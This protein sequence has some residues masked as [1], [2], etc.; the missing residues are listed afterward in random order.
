[1][2]RKLTNLLKSLVFLGSSYVCSELAAECVTE[3]P[4]VIER[5]LFS[6]GV[7]CDEA[8]S[9]LRGYAEEL[10]RIEVARVNGSQVI[11]EK[12]I[13]NESQSERIR[14]VSDSILEVES[15]EFKGKSGLVVVRAKESPKRDNYAKDGHRILALERA[16]GKK[17]SDFSGVNAQDLIGLDERKNTIE[18]MEGKESLVEKIEWVVKRVNDSSSIESISINRNYSASAIDVET[19]IHDMEKLFPKEKLVDIENGKKAFGKALFVDVSKLKPVDVASLL[20][21]KGAFSYQGP[22]YSFATHRKV[23][24]AKCWK[25]MR[26]SSCEFRKDGFNAILIM[27][28]KTFTLKSYK[29]SPEEM[30]AAVSR[31]G[32]KLERS[33]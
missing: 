7:R 17:D 4:L 22:E 33:E 2:K 30:V 9:G 11:V 5:G 21:S 6:V 18:S 3:K 20:E 1:M 15:S 8:I 29:L 31:D 14:I 23:A 13:E 24:L 19:R 10:A 28:K 16:L 32:I 12:T 26:R 25:G 27:D